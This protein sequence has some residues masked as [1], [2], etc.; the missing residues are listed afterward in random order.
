MTVRYYKDLIMPIDKLP[1]T[2]AQPGRPRV[3]NVP[4]RWPLKTVENDKCQKM[5][6]QEVGTVLN[7]S[8][9]KHVI[10]RSAR[11]SGDTCSTPAKSTSQQKGYMDSY[12]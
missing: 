7:V 9:L 2:T 10:G 6:G 3:Q 11:R 4:F 5:Y 8:S 1:S 12:M